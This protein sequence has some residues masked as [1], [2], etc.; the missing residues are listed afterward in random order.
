M[1]AVVIGSILSV[2]GAIVIVVFLGYKVS[3][4]IAQ[5]AERHRKT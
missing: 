1:D 2:V 3:K 4:L 5:D